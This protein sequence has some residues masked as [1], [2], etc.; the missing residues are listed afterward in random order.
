MSTF[1]ASKKKATR[2]VE[3]SAGMPV[4]AKGTASPGTQGGES[5]QS[6]Y[7]LEFS[8]PGLPGTP[9]AREHHM[10]KARHVKDWRTKVY[11]KAWPHAP[12]QPLTQARI[13]FT[14]V[15]SV[16]PDYDNLVASFKACMDGLR[17][18]RVIVDDKRVNVGRPEYLWERCKPKAGH[19][20]VR[21]ESVTNTKEQT[22]G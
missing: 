15:S 20:R 13:T 2:K 19:I 16:E 17:Q 7:L 9:N 3:P 21:V 10:A 12:A 11:A 5:V 18:A 8:I 22:N 6:P 4:C 1:A 14:R